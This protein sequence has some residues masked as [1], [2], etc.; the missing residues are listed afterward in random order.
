M[1]RDG[2]WPSP[3]YL[4][5]VRRALVGESDMTILQMV[6]ATASGAVARYLP[7][8]RIDE[9]AHRLVAA[10]RRAIDLAPPGDLRVIWARALIGL[11]VT[12]EDARLAAGLIDVPPNG[13]AVDQDMRWA[14]A[15]RWMAL[16]LEGAEERVTSET[17][18][19]RS[20]RGERAVLTANAARPDPET[21]EDVWERLH[22]HGYDSLQ[23]AM[24]AAAGFWWRTQRTLVEPYVPR[25]FDG[26]PGLF[27]SWE[28]EAARAY[29]RAMFPGYRVEESTREHIS[30]V[31]ARLDLGPML[32]R[33][34]VE[35]ED[36]LARAITAR[37]VAAESV[38]APEGSPGRPD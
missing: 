23:L 26:L 25:F 8:E 10:A 1:V 12:P 2:G 4:E 32:R 29:Y 34:L 22:Q 20:D 27:E 35:S 13:L 19:D 3:D 16:G 36:D 38:G 17:L 37:R 21:K 14:V 18:R 31:L 5:L 9:E 15:V 6:T 24:A 7:E 11:A 28:A 33:L 30:K